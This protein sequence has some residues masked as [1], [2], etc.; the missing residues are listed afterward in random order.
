VVHVAQQRSL[1]LDR[2]LIGALVLGAC[3]ATLAIP[4]ATTLWHETWST[5]AGAQGPLIAVIGGWLI[6]R[7]SGELARDA[8]PGNLAVASL[9][10]A[11]SLIAYTLGRAFDFLT[12]EVAGLYGAGIAIAYAFLG[13][14]VL[15][16]HWF[17]FA[18]LAL[19]I[20]PPAFL[21]DRATAPLKTFVSIIATSI[22][23]HL[24]MPIAREGV[25]IFVGQYQLLV[26]DAC[27]G[28]NSI[29][30][31][32]AITLLWAYLAYRS[33]WR[34]SLLLL[35]CALPIA[36]AAN[37]L[38]IMTLVLL[39]YFAGDAVAQGFLHHTAGMFIFALALVLVFLVDSVLRRFAGAG[40][41][42]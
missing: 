32:T 2:N 25:T 42:A 33:S 41:S 14:A 12:I 20:P 17:P 38:R 3:F 18:Y 35:A 29:I 28:V 10:M 11:A 40:K 34:Y 23:S 13:W 15:R 7:I 30:G 4:T 22:L 27:S 37:I 39:T 16:R 19:A 24:G 9:G 1:Q 8:K 31:I 36:I 21:M 26:A 6:W 5:E